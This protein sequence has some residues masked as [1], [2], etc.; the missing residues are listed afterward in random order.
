MSFD[1]AAWL[2]DVPLWWR[3][4]ASRVSPTF[5]R[6]PHPAPGFIDAR[7]D[8]GCVPTITSLEA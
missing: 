1:Y 4:E 2:D 6:N 7:R 3:I 8:D 5:L